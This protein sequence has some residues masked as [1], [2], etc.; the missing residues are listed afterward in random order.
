MIKVKGYVLRDAWHINARAYPGFR[1]MERLGVLLLLLD[2]MLSIGGNPP[3]LRQVSQTVC[4]CP[5]ILLGG[6]RH[7]ESKASCPSTQHK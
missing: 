4:W 6:E 2:G 5:F 7:D 3:A 1:S